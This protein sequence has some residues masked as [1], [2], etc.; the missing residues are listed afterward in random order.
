MTDWR[1]RSGV[2]LVEIHGVY[3]LAADRE[4]RRTCNFVC[5]VNEI[6]AFIWQLMSEGKTREEMID[7]IQQA[8][9]LPEGYDPGEDLDLFIQ[10]LRDNNYIVCEDE[11]NEI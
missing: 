3:L 5:R 9:E 7:E 11:K 4:A 2:V 8:Y 10:S 1:L 6:G